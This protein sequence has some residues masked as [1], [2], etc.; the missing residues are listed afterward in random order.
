MAI[1]AQTRTELVQLVVSMLGEAPSTAMLTDLVTK[2]NAGSTV[3]EL[4][5]SLATN[6]AFTSQFPVWMTATEFT[7]KIVA[8]MFAGSS[9]AQADT[10]A[11]VDYIAGMITAG[12]FTKTSAVVALT[13]YLASADGV[14]N[15]TYGSAAQSYQNKVEV[16]EYYTITKG[17]GNASAEE[18]KAAIAGVTSDAATVTAE[19][20]TTDTA[21]T[22]ATAI[23][24]KVLTLTSNTD[25]IVGGSGDDTVNASSTTFNSDDVIDLKAGSDQFSIAATGNAT[26]IA[27][28]SNT[29]LV[30]VTQGGAGGTDYGLNMIA[31]T[32]VENVMSRLSTGEVSFDNLQNMV[33]VHAYG[34]Q[35]GANVTAGFLNA[36]ASGTADSVSLILD[37]GANAT[38]QVSGTTDT[39]EFETINLSS[40]G[41]TANTVSL[42]DAG[43]NN[44]AGLKTYNVTGAAKLTQTLAGGASKATFDA[45]T[46]TGAQVLTWGGNY[47]TIKTGTAADTIKTGASFFGANNT[48]AVDGGDGIDTL[49][50]TESIANFTSNSATAPHTVTG[51]EVLEID[52]SLAAGAG[53]DLTITVEADLFTLD[54]IVIDADNNDT[55]AA[56]S[57]GDDV[58]V[59]VN[60]LSATQAVT[61]SANNNNAVAANTIDVTLN[62]KTDTGAADEINITTVNPSAV[63]LSTIASLTID[64]A[65]A[66]P[67]SAVETVNL[68]GS[69]VGTATLYGTTVASLDAQYSNTL[70]LKGTGSISLT[71]L[72]I[73]DPAGTATAVVD[74]SAMT[75]KLLL[76]AAGAGFKATGGD[77]V[78][79]TLGSGTNT[80]HF[81]TEILSADVIV[82]TTGAKDL[83][84]IKEAA[85]DL[86]P[87][88]TNIDTV[89][90]TGAGAS[91]TISAKKFTDVGTIAIY[92]G[93]AGDVTSDNISVKEIATGQAIDIY[94]TTATQGDWDG[95]TITLDLATGVTAANLGIKGTVA[96]EGTG[97]ISS[98][99]IAMGLDMGNKVTATGLTFDQT[100]VLSNTSAL[101]PLSTLTLTGGGMK[102]ATAAATTTITATNNVN[103]SS[104][105]ASGYTGNLNI[106]GATTKAAGVVTLGAGN[107]T[108]TVALADL[109]RDALSINGGD[110]TDTLVA[111]DLAAALYRP[112]LSNI[113]KL[114]ID[115]TTGTATEL[116]LLD[117]TGVETVALD[118]DSTDENFTISGASAITTY[119]LEAAAAATADIITL[120]SAATLS[121]VNKTAAL[122]DANTSL[123]FPN[124]TDLSLAIGK[125]T[126][127]VTTAAMDLTTLT[128]AK[129]TSM[130]VGG[131]G[132]DAATGAGYIGK[133]DIANLTTAKLTSLT[134]DADQGDIDLDNVTAAKLAAVT[135]TGDNALAFGG[136][137]GSTA[138][139]ASFDASAMT[140]AVT[141]GTGIDFT[142]SAS[143]KT[144]TANDTV[145]LDVLTEGNATL[146]MGTKLAD[147]DTLNLDGANNMGLSVIDLSAADQISQLNGAVN[148]GVQSGIESFNASGLTGSQGVT[149][150]GSAAANTLT[151]T[152]NADNFIGGEGADTI[153]TGAGNDTVSLTESTAK[154]D[155]VIFATAATNGADTI[156]GFK[157]GT[158]GDTIDLE[159]MGGGNMAA[160]VALAANAAQADIASNSIVV[161]A[162]GDDGAGADNAITQI[163]DYTAMADVAAFINAGLTVATTEVFVAVINDLVTDKAY[164][165]NVVEAGNTTIDAGEVT[166]VGTLTASNA[167]TP[168]TVAN[169]VFTA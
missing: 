70:N 2:A 89:K 83:V 78:T 134:I 53:A 137:G 119:Q 84:V 142:A 143:I 52:G 56:T 24:A 146:D 58:I 45:S 168:F 40:N 91:K 15:A 107:N 27:N 149:I 22:A 85:T 98:D 105:D 132:I 164:V 166:L 55:A 30:K 96:L 37:G 109:A 42:K 136:T 28:L 161:F 46:A 12:T 104:I 139:L 75:D 114:D 20:A 155:N 95:G 153:T 138:A 33:G 3:Q 122:G 140:G 71:A 158:G 152:A 88:I 144:G 34:T 118:L 67:L 38:F 150:T 123:V 101:T 72:E 106:A 5:D 113:E 39:N 57:N 145:T 74:A 100:V 76:G 19:K 41:T 6:A 103:L 154:V 63:A 120:G 110:G 159:T 29:E 43:G 14:A 68:T 47:T 11:A 73:A 64:R 18:R 148:A 48:K 26:T 23:P 8:N 116:S 165:Y 77:T 13:S 127:N 49:A 163:A 90:A 59:T 141:I 151:G 129:A 157:F 92:D 97:I 131:Q 82:G 162:D 94:S 61:M 108:V 121:V 4:A 60:D 80:V 81:D 62:M 112:G 86:V 125:S 111:V 93:A 51:I 16:A 160:E 135:A 69:A 167:D 115:L 87:T 128:A 35:A 50:V 21:A 147:N 9:V 99:I 36:L 124:A 130:T 126:A 169:T 7:S 117:S 79:L 10:D 44:P 102:S 65:A 31:A 17:L 1:T 54:S 25:N 32:G 66:S 133:L 156:T